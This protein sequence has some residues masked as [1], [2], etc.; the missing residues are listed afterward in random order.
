MSRRVT[1]TALAL[2]MLLA[3][4]ASGADLPPL[5]VG[6]DRFFAT[7]DG[8][9]QAAAGRLLLTELS[10]TA[11]HAPPKDTGESLAPKRGPVL[12]GIGRRVTAD[13]LRQAIADPSSARPRSTMPQMFSGMG[14]DEKTDA[15]E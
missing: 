13:W 12:D 6:F 15:V 11:C 9:P 3:G 7:A 14:A 2:G 10:C 1:T 5:V 4:A 8:P